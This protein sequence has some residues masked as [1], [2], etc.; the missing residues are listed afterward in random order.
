[1]TI[2]EHKSKPVTKKCAEDIYGNKEINCFGDSLTFGYGGNETTYPATLQN[3]LGSEYQVNN[4]GV[5]GE[6]TLTIAGRQGSI[7]MQVKAMII[8]A[9][10]KTVEIEF[11]EQNYPEITSEVPKPLRQGEA[12]INPCYLGGMKGN[13]TITQSTTT[14]EDAK[15]YFTREEG[16][17]KVY[18]KE[19]EALITQASQS[20]RNGILILWTGTNDKL[21]T[22]Q[23]D[24]VTALINKQKTMINYLES[25]EKKYIVL[26][27][28][29]VKDMEASGIEKINRELEKEYGNHFIDIRRRIQK[30]GLSSSNL[31]ETEQ[32]RL[33]YKAGNIPLSLRVDEVHLNA[34]GYRFIGQEVYRK[35]REL[36]YW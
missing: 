33:D 22:L 35:G 12:G 31:P 19:G 29:F 7:P 30:D 3:M 18:I 24:S 2:L 10:G 25:T 27:L 20:K 28:T 26:G 17:E 8:P 6:S 34:C 36:G 9:N 4:L 5:G 15:W 21:K 14:S 16:E 23:T 32:D 1:M 11:L 13:L